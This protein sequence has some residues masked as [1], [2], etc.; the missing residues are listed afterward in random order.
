MIKI[1]KNQSKEKQAYTSLFNPSK[2]IK[3]CIHTDSVSC[4]LKHACDYVS[5]Y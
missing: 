2:L 5:N 3:L 4:P 1:L